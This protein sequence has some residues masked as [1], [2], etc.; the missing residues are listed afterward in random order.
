[1]SLAEQLVGRRIAALHYGLPAAW[2]PMALSS[3]IGI[4]PVAVRVGAASLAVYRDGAGMIRAVDDRCPHRRMRLSKGRLTP[5]G[6]LQC[7]YHGWTFDGSTGQCVSIPNLRK[8]EAVS[9]GYK[10]ARALVAESRP[11]PAPCVLGETEGELAAM[12]MAD[13][14]TSDGIVYVWTGATSPGE[15]IDPGSA[16]MPE[17]PS[18]R[19]REGRIE[20]RA[21]LER[22]LAAV[23]LNPG[24]AL[25]MGLLFGSGEAVIDARFEIDDRH[26]EI[27]RERVALDLPRVTS[28]DFLI[29][30]T[31]R[32][33]IRMALAT[34]KA[35]ISAEDERG[36]VD[37]RLTVA[38]T[39]V[40]PYR[41]TLR[42]RLALYTRSAEFR[43]ALAVRIAAVERRLG[44][45]SRLLER[46]TDDLE[47]TADAPL[48]ALR[49]RLPRFGG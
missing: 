8:G 3:E 12:T 9:P 38:C 14:G 7:P 20:A 49:Q 31:L 34:G 45:G 44:R 26:V 18:R 22:V 5:D 41:T 46:I 16:S 11:S 30:K 2:W 13:V 15:V 42:W 29:K 39:P 37:A 23:A 28:Y 6:H 27:E 19:I 4:A 1:M 36:S 35:V 48:Q 43:A 47:E 10:V 24:R 17:A 25:G 33:R 32:S 21:P 40:D